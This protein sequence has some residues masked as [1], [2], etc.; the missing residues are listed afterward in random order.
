MTK[1]SKAM[2]Q[3]NK[4]MM[5]A[6]NSKGN[7]MKDQERDQK[8]KASLTRAGSKQQHEDGDIH[9]HVAE[10][11]KRNRVSSATPSANKDTLE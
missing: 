3:S 1:Y 2:I 10:M 6:P 8:T 7:G 4:S 11:V 5:R 9:F